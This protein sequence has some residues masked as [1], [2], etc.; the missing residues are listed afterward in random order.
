MK[1]TIIG[2]FA[3][4]VAAGAASAADLPARKAPDFVPPP[5]LLYDGLYFGV[6]AGAAGFADLAQSVFTPNGAVLS[7]T[8]SHGGSFIGGFHAGY[9]WRYGPLVFGLIG[10][11]S[12]ARAVSYNVDPFFG[13]GVRN[14]I[15]AQGSARGRVGLV[16]DRALLYVTGGLSL[17][18]LRREYRA[19]LGAQNYNYLIGEPTLGAGVE[20][21]IDPHWSAN[22]EYR[23][24]GGRAPVEAAN[25]ARPG[26]ETKHAQGE[27][28]ITAG[29]SYRFGK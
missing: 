22:V 10:D 28:L 3:A 13:Y 29:V 24:F 4:L 11:I 17:S 23:V 7:H 20:Y 15:D 9:D 18:H 12:G 27:G 26:L 16:Y 6:Q 8:T 14:A 1:T 21:A 19:P 25:F 2:P 5:A